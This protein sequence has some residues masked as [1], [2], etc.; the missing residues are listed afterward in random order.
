MFPPHRR[1]QEV[2][3]TAIPLH[4]MKAYRGMGVQVR[5]FLTSALYVGEQFYAP[6]ALSL[7]KSLVIY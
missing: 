5:P 7:G 1:F 3:T 6:A 4:V 2:T